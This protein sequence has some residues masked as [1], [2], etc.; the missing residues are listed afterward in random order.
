MREYVGI[1]PA[2]SGESCAQVGSP[3]YYERVVAECRAYIQ[4]IRKM[5]GEE[6]VGARLAVKSFPHDFGTYSEVVC[7]YDDNF[8]D[9]VDYAFRCEGEAPTTWA[10]AGMDV[11]RIAGSSA[12]TQQN[13]DRKRER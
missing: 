9:A 10:E 12:S 11:L 4:A 5:L 7:Y 2:P 1:G 13:R 6:P 3:D 8:P